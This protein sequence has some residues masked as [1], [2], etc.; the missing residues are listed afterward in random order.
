MTCEVYKNETCVLLPR[1]VLLLLDNMSP[2]YR[3]IC[4]ALL[5]TQMRVE[6]FWWFVLH[7]DAYR[8]SRRCIHLPKEAIGKTTTIYNERD[9]I[10]SIRG[11]Q[12]VEHLI[13][14][15]LTKK[16]LMSRQAMGQYLNRIANESGLGDTYICPKMFRKT[17]ISWLVATFPEKQA[18]INSSAGHTALV[19]LNNYLGTAFPREA[20]EDMVGLLK[21][22]GDA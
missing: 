16:D 18:W 13:S 6:E 5:H 1:E 14:L 20:K 19:Q 4:E 22:W 8:P 17:M 10:L 3:A 9:V 15:K 7:P 12:I 11:C 21:G 2:K